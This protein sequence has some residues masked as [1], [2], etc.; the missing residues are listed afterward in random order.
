MLKQGCFVLL[1]TLTLSCLSGCVGGLWTGATMVYDRHDVYKKLDD[2]SLYLKVN[3]AITVDNTFKS[4]QCVIDIA[5]FHGDILIVGHVPTR[6][7]QA[8]L[9]RRL[10]QVKGYRRLFDE[11]GVNRVASNS[12]QDRWITTKIRSQVFADSS[13]DPNSFKVVTSE[14]IVYLM[15]DVHSEQAV[16]VIHIA[17]QT[18]DV[19]RVVNML[20]FFTYQ[21]KTVS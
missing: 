10:S 5:V 8:E 3:N 1:I 12:V 19:V 9:R 13:I 4:P 20:Q 7:M 6:E 18:T 17:R 15:G 16:K 14:Q 21:N 2:Y 11:V